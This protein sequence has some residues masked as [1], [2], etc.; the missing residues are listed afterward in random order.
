MGEV[1]N[2]IQLG[3]EVTADM[4]V[5]RGPLGQIIDLCNSRQVVS[6]D[7]MT[8]AEEIWPSEILAIINACEGK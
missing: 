1:I 3:L 7:G 2:A 4:S 6:K 8:D 5:E